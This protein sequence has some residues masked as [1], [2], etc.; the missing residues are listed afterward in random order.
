MRSRIWIHALVAAGVA[1]GAGA[2]FA[3][4]ASGQQGPK[5]AEQPSTA[6]LLSL[7]NVLVNNAVLSGYRGMGL[8]LQFDLASQWAVRGAVDLSRA[9]NPVRI[10]K[11]TT[12]TGT[13][14]QV[15]YTF[16]APGT[17]SQYSGTVGVDLIRRLGTR[18]MA[19]YAGFGVWADWTRQQTNYSDDISV[20]DQVTNVN[21][22]YNSRGFGFEGVLGIAWR[23][24]ESISL[25]A[26]YAL[27][28]D[29]VRWTSTNN[30]T[31][32]KSTASG[33]EA[34]TRQTHSEDSETK[35]FNV[36]MSLGQGA[37]LGLMAHF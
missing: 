3:E 34:S 2:A 12:T 24:H 16:Q 31:T 8:G 4:E 9:T 5:A 37:S 28:L 17:T 23:V 10:S 30:Q 14:T 33:L 7:N 36:D 26:E 22:V 18:A 11:V 13:D 19:P 29:V 25:F 35:W 15:D 6:L 27:D 32:V 20:V 1:V 21:N